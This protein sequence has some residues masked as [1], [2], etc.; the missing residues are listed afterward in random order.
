MI[1]NSNMSSMQALFEKVNKNSSELS[2][3]WRFENHTFSTR[4]ANE[5]S[6]NLTN[7]DNLKNNMSSLTNL[8]YANNTSNST[9]GISIDDEEDEDDEKKK[10]SKFIIKAWLPN[11][12]TDL[13]TFNDGDVEEYF[14]LNKFDR[15]K[16]VVKDAENE[17]EINDLR[18]A[19]RG[20]E[21]IPGFSSSSNDNN[22]S[23]N[24]DTGKM[25]QN[26]SVNT[27]TNTSDINPEV[28]TTT[29]NEKS[30]DDIVMK[31]KE[32][33]NMED[34]DKKDIIMEVKG[35]ETLELEGKEKEK[36]NT[37]NKDQM[38]LKIKDLKDDINME[39]K[40]D[41][42]MKDQDDV[43]QSKES[44][45]E[46]PSNEANANEEVENKMPEQLPTDEPLAAA[47][48]SNIEA[49]SVDADGDINIS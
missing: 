41:V 33:I 17:K 35:Q 2:I 27:T 36:T 28:E 6:S 26:A 14:D 49:K 46:K 13:S 29:N 30:T 25:E 43:E 20:S 11:K 8:E 7:D 47:E 37:E 32:D 31:E 21:S 5:D 12:P 42:E 1:Y 40:A 48:N 23:S 38:E 44:I 19:M 15:N 16:K 10:Y 34:K 4:S 39:E 22:S 18:G 9:T 24:K 3:S 45:S